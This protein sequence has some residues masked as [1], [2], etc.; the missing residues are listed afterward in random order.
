[1]KSEAEYKQERARER[2][3]DA[4]RNKCR[5]AMPELARR[6]FALRHRMYTGAGFHWAMEKELGSVIAMLNDF[7]RHFGM[8][9]EIV[10]KVRVQGLYKDVAK[11]E[12]SADEWSRR[13]A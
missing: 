1:M 11:A 7:D 6:V 12:Q 10:L 9:T 5:D 4:W 2:V 13:S 8:S 3:F